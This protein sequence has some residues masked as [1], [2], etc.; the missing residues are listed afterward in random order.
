MPNKTP[1][2]RNTGTFYRIGLVRK[3]RILIACTLRKTPTCAKYGRVARERR[4][5][6]HPIIS[7]SLAKTLQRERFKQT[8]LFSTMAFDLLGVKSLKKP[9]IG[10]L[11]L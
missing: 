2:A 10:C 5:I 1:D 6:E 7:E 4:A 9:K 8:M 11:F 3:N